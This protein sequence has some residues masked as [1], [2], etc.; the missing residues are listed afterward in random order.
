MSKKTS[1]MA[2]LIDQ[3]IGI[4]SSVGKVTERWP[5]SDDF[6]IQR[7][8][9]GAS[10]TILKDPHDKVVRC[11][12]HH[13]GHPYKISTALC[14]RLVAELSLRKCWVKEAIGS[15]DLHGA[16]LALYQMSH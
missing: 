6:A 3:V 4:D 7:M 16:T 12:I 8:N 11:T 14:D 10:L 5:Y 15:L 13:I 9:L 1:Q 2:D